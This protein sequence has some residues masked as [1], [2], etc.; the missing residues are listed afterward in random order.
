MRRNSLK[1]NI[2]G[3]LLIGSAFA[4]ASY[5]FPYFMAHVW[6]AVGNDIYYRLSSEDIT[7]KELEVFI[8]SREKA[9]EWANLEKAKTDLTILPLVS[10]AHRFQAFSSAETLKAFLEENPHD[11]FLWLRLSELQ[12]RTAAPVSD[13]LHSWR[14]SYKYIPYEPNITYQRFYRGLRFKEFLMP[15]DKLLIQSELEGA[16]RHYQYGLRLKVQQY[17]LQEVIDEFIV[18]ERMR[19]I[20][21]R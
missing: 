10:D 21:L 19:Q 1:K 16:F 15:E 2:F 9:I 11:G 14:Q 7:A 20:L 3:V 8:E 5:S 6:M 18:D 4:L 17:K 13:I 12:E